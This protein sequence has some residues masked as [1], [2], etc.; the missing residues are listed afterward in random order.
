MSA[1]AHT[2]LFYKYFYKVVLKYF[3]QIAAYVHR[4]VI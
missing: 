3:H 4:F 1:Y 2:A